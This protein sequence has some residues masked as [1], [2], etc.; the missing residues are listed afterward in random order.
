MVCNF[1]DSQDGKIIEQCML[2]KSQQRGNIL[3]YMILMQK[4]SKVVKRNT[5]SHSEN[6]ENK[7]QIK[8]MSISLKYDC[9]DHKWKAQC[10]IKIYTD[11]GNNQF[12]IILDK[13]DL[14]VIIELGD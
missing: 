11:R 4:D 12:S 1:N 6:S 8:V 14:A 10:F 9:R 3:S 2:E 13:R 5:P 7:I